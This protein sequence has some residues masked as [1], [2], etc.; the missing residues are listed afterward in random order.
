MDKDVI[1]YHTQYRNEWSPERTRKL[2]EYP[3]GALEFM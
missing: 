3:H 2:I 1:H